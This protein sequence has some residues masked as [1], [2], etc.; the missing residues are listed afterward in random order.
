VRGRED[1]LMRV[2]SKFHMINMK[3]IIV[4]DRK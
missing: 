3:F 2:R 1:E 4:S